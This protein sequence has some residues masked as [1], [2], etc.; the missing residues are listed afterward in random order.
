MALFVITLDECIILHSWPWMLLLMSVIYWWMFMPVL[1]TY[2]S[3]H[4]WDVWWVK[5]VDKECFVKYLIYMGNVVEKWYSKVKRQY[6]WNMICPRM[7]MWGA[8]EIFTYGWIIVM[9]RF[10]WS[11]QHGLIVLHWLEGFYFFHF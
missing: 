7:I 6:R 1:L 5:I 9:R 4:V 10:T 8:C 3:E 2:I 11:L